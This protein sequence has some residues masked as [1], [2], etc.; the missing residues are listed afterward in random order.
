MIFDTPGFTSFDVLEAE[1]EELQHF[2]PETAAGLL[3]RH[4]DI[5][6]CRHL[7]EPGC[8]VQA[9]SRRRTRSAIEPIRVIYRA[10]WK[11]SARQDSTKTIYVQKCEVTT[12]IE[13]APSILSA[14]F[15][16]LGEDVET[17]RECRSASDPCRCHGRTFCTEYQLSV[18]R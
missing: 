10:R 3:G 5:S 13:L 8:S 17:N 16:R 11:R 1:E 14:D 12:M 6:D 15:S 18:Q 9:G 7:A 2:F 4:A